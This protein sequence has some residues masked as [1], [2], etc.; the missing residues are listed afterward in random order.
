[1]GGAIFVSLSGMIL[2]VHLTVINYK[3][4]GKKCMYSS[5]VIGALLIAIIITEIIVV[6]IKLGNR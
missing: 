3:I 2:P 6:V 5:C 1:M 4:F